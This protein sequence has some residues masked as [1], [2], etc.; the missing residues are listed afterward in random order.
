MKKTLL[1]IRHAKAEEPQAHLTDFDRKL[2]E[3]G[4]REAQKM[5]QM[6]R[7]E[8]L[9]PELILSSPAKRATM[10]AEVFA[11]ELSYAESKIITEPAIYEAT[12]E[13][14]LQVVNQLDNNFQRVMLICHNPASHT[15]SAYL[16]GED[17]FDLPTAGVVQIVFDV[18]S[19]SEVSMGI[20]NLVWVRTTNDN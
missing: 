1:I 6:I 2:T 13:S 16:T 11:E 19:W 12:T 17:I 10:T 9:I 5:A 7:N 20:G 18:D 8:S 4:L 3:K 15:L 14:L